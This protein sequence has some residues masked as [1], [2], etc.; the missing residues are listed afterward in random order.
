LQSFIPP[1]K[2]II[3]FLDDE[4]KKEKPMRLPWNVN[5]KKRQ[6]QRYKWGN[7]FEPL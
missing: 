5:E 3:N 7:I 6:E 2:I 4:W 1:K